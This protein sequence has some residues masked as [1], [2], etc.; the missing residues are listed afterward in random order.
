MILAHHKPNQLHHL[1]SSIILKMGDKALFILHFD[2]KSDF[3]EF[4]VIKSQFAQQLVFLDHS[5]EISWGGLSIVKATMALLNHANDCYRCRH[6]VLISGEDAVVDLDKLEYLG[7]DTSWMNHWILPYASWWGGG[8]FRIDRPHFFDNKKRRNLNFSLYRYA[9]RLF[10]SFAP[11]TRM[12]KHFPDMVFYGGQQWMVLN[13][14]AVSYLLKF[15][16]DNPKI[17]DVFKYSFAPDELFIQT[18][19][20]N[21]KSL[22]V[23]NKP[24]HYVRF[25][26]FDSSPDY[27]NASDIHA[28]KN[29][30]E[31]LFARKYAG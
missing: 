13:Q 11:Q 12:S 2:K 30:G 18:I 15:V 26:G 17:W 5:F 6:L 10:N 20:C 29:Q 3:N 9:D 28:L 16:N 7:S 8:M 14:E 23:L 21:N 27:L 31:F 19:L 24:T 22:K 4:N 25:N 1:V